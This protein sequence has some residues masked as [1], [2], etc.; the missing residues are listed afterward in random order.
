VKTL[1]TDFAY[2]GFTQNVKS[3]QIDSSAV[4]ADTG[5]TL[6]IL[7]SAATLGLALGAIKWRGVGLGS[8]GVLFAGLI[9]G[10][11]VLPIDPETLHFVREFGLLLFVFTMGLQLGPGFFA[12][13]RA[14]G[15]ASNLLAVGIVVTGGVIVYAFGLLLKLEPGILPGLFSGSTTNT[16]SLGAVQQTMATMPEIPADE[17]T[18]PA[19]AY[20]AVYPIGILGSIVSILLLQKLWKVD[21]EAEEQELKDLAHR[22]NPSLDRLNIVVENANLDGILLKDFPGMQEM[23]VSVS[24]VRPAGESGVQTAT[25]DTIIYQGDRLLAVGTKAHLKKF[26]MIVGHRSDDDLMQDQQA[27]TFRRIVVTRKTLLGKPLRTLHLDGRFGV[28]ITRMVRSGVEMPARGSL[29]LQFGDYL[30]VVGRPDG[31]DAAEK[32]LGN[33]LEALNTTRFVTVFLGLALGVLLGMVPLSIPGLAS[34]MK[35]GL[36]GGPLIVAIL[37]SRV[38][39]IGPLVWHM[40]QNTNLA[41]RELG[42]VLFLATVG[43]GAGPKFFEI[44]FSSQGLIWVG[45]AFFIATIPL[46]L[47]GI[48]ARKVLKM[49]FLSIIGLLSGSMTDPPALAFAGALTKSDEPALAYATVYPIAMLSRIVVAQLLVIYL[50][51]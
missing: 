36:A 2:A 7:A 23:E 38:G 14:A 3:A 41:F 4:F 31:L 35:L 25:T 6:V 40:P 13:L 18:L 15:L 33:S 34:P 9:I 44:A 29:K 8:T 12:S 20:S 19:L 47:A 24:R 21:L 49:N 10:S 45:C 11:F 27:V 48:V 5:L 22:R 1:G 51:H 16:P 28:T 30:Q 37:L 46:L 26:E 32:E 17:L 50:F 39:R 42:I 43:L